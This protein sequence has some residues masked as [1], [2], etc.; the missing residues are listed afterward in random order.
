MSIIYKYQN[1][2]K[3]LKQDIDQGRYTADF[4]L[5]PQEQLADK[6]DT[7]RMTIKKA[8]A[9]LSNDGLIYSNQGSG[10]FI[11]K[12]F[13]ASNKELLPLAAPKGAT[14]SHAGNQIKSKTL[15]FSARLPY[16]NEQ[17][18]LGITANEPV[19]EIQ[20][21]RYVDNRVYSFE[22][23]VMP[24]SIAVID[25]KVLEGSIYDYLQDNAGITLKG[26]R[27]TV[28]ASHADKTVAAALKIQPGDATLVIEQTAF[29][30][31]GQPFEHSLSYFLPD[32]S[33][34]YIDININ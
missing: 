13:D 32:S 8:L 7:S 27:R 6:Y 20:R 12:S 17:E 33:K 11:R 15:Q 22:Q 34:F 24:T 28:Y 14:N 19:Y 31:T 3:Q 25:Q 5:P 30:Q 26:A 9:L 23:T 10:T 29:S 1:I 18:S 4:P 21:V 2:Y 16:E